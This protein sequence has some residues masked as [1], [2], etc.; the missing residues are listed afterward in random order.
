MNNK[1]IVRDGHMHSPYCPHGTK[2]SFEMYVD[3]ALIEGLEENNIY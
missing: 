1:K 2:D 3:K